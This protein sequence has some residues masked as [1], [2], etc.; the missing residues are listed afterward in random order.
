MLRTGAYLL[1]EDEDEDDED[2]EEEGGG[3]GIGG[4]DKGKRKARFH[5]Q[6]I[7]TILNTSTKEVEY[8][9][10]VGAGGSSIFAKASFVPSAEPELR[11]HE[12]DEEEEEEEEEEDDD[13][14]NQSGAAAE[15]GAAAGGGD[16]RAGIAV[17]DKDFW[18]KMLPAAEA[19]AGKLRRQL[20]DADELLRDPQTTPPAA[21]AASAASAAS[22]GGGAPAMDA[23]AAAA[24]AAT[25]TNTTSE[26]AGGDAF[27]AFAAAVR[28]LAEPLHEARVGGASGDDPALESMVEVIEL[29]EA[30]AFARADLLAADERRLAPAPAKAAPAEAAPA[31]AAAKEVAPVAATVR[32]RCR[33]RAVEISLLCERAAAWAAGIRNPK[34]R[35]QKMAISD[36][37]D[38]DD[39]DFLDDVTQEDIE[40]H[41]SV[42]A[43]QRF[44]KKR[45]LAEQKVERDA[46][47]ARKAEKK[48][49]REAATNRLREQLA[50]D[51][52]ARRAQAQ[53]QYQTQ[54]RQTQAAQAAMP[55][56]VRQQ[57]AALIGD[58]NLR[59]QQ[60]QQLMTRA[61]ALADQG[62]A[63]RAKGTPVGLADGARYQTEGQECAHHASVLTSEVKRLESEVLALQRQCA[64]LPQ[65]PP[66]PPPYHQ[67]HQHHQHHHH[68]PHQIAA[69]PPAGPAVGRMP[70]GQALQALPPPLAPSPAMAQAAQTAQAGVARLAEKTQAAHAAHAAAVRLAEIQRRGGRV[71]RQFYQDFQA[72]FPAEA[73]AELGLTVAPGTQALVDGSSPVV[74][75]KAVRAG[76]P[77]AEA[78]LEAED[79][80]LKL[81]EVRLTC[82]APHLDAAA[83]ELL[84]RPPARWAAEGGGDGTRI[85]IFRRLSSQEVAPSRE[86]VAALLHQARPGHSVKVGWS[87]SVVIT[88]E[89]V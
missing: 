66:Q 87:A 78:G 40:E 4:K 44:A 61:E 11:H 7:D 5:E 65:A 70:I 82:G 89:P 62:H 71:V 64:S 21:F 28:V 88:R 85:L 20:L 39:D 37:E 63:E 9:E 38:E 3:G 60:K 8:K 53:A 50:R 52:E 25:A 27:A 1:G 14:L 56:Q 34:R 69:P 2:K 22:V 24:A 41:G 10:S 19:P 42:G 58:L 36:G 30:V 49:E 59:R 55:P 48:R 16:A 23:A 47:R 81:N 43:A 76:S 35:R 31:E 67:H 54:L 86:E 18:N 46:E 79:M 17:G 33:T 12:D 6:D 45:K 73:S 74:L 84:G 77:A 72:D 15:R 68:R 29:L 57:L 51:A 32:P 26:E 83:I 80:L 13:P 75:V